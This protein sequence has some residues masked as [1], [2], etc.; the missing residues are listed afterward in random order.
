MLNPSLRSAVENL[1]GRLGFPSMLDQL[2]DPDGLPWV[3]PGRTVAIRRGVVTVG[4]VGSVH[5]QVSQKMQLPDTTAIANLD[6]RAL[7]TSGVEATRFRAIPRFPSQ[8]VDVALLV[9]QATR[10][11]DVSRFLD[12]I[13]GTL[14][15]S[16]RLF[17]VYRGAGL[18]EDHKSLNFTV[19]LGADDRTLTTADEEEYLSKVRQR[20][21]DVGAQLRG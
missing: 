2:V 13:G 8:P 10:V 7:L 9:P 18:P 21:G 19:T 11:V 1:L 5:P 6:L 17:E 14:V 15:R 3:H 16:V 4:Y 12:D 20:A